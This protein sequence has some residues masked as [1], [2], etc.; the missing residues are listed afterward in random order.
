MSRSSRHLYQDLSEWECKRCG[1]KKYEWARF[2]SHK[3][4]FG[5][6]H[7]KYCPKCGWVRLF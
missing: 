7:G 6:R 1:A 4:K 5:H 2:G 3:D